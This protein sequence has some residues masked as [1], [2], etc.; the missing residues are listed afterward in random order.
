MRNPDLYQAPMSLVSGEELVAH[1]ST[2]S[3]TRV[4]TGAWLDEAAL[5]LPWPKG[6]EVEVRWPRTPPPLTEAEIAAA[7]ESPAGQ[8][9]LRE[10]CRGKQ[11]PVIVLDDLNRP[12]PGDRILPAVFQQL[13]QGGIAA[14]QVTV[15]VATG[16]HI[17]PAKDLLIKKIGKEVAERCRVVTHDHTRNNVSVGRTSF[18]TPVQVDRAAVGCDLMVG[19]GGAY[20]GYKGGFGGGSKL[21]LG[22]LS[23]R[24]IK[25]LHY[26]HANAGWGLGSLESNFRRDLDE[27]AHIIGLKTCITV[28][29]NANREV[30]RVASGDYRRF[31]SEALAF[32][33]E[34]F[35]VPGP[36]DA[37][38]V[39]CNAYPSDSS[40]L[41]AWTKASTPLHEC[42][43]S[44]TRV[45]I[46]SCH[47]G[48][49]GHGLFPLE[50][51]PGRV[52]N[53]LRRLSVMQASEALGY[54]ASKAAD[55]VLR[56]AAPASICPKPPARHPVCLY[57]TDATAEKRLPRLPGMTMSG[58][59]R[60]VIETVLREQKGKSPVR[61]VVYPCSSL[62]VLSASPS[63]NFDHAHSQTAA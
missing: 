20:P 51:P 14:E 10:L 44:A 7:L 50:R 58:S 9:P 18:G 56:R 5:E 16:T 55:K 40:L 15:L 45:L 43:A 3:E 25:H 2:G 13:A 37:D 31:F 46:A 27:V 57:L 61:V 35:T 26:K 23:T 42:K 1:L 34:C 39:V 59:W 48:A 53:L 41:L 63:V 28:H 24:S 60:Q 19:I 6:W 33:A 11:R 12:T 36:G 54:L 30:V 47:E 38:V 8:P 21:A 22:I 29:V 49:G 32:T 52:K 17:A 4:R 62:Q